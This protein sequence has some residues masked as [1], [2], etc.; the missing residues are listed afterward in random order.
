MGRPEIFLKNVPLF[1]D[2]SVTDIRRIA[3]LVEP[4]F[5]RKGEVLFRRG[6]EGTAFYIIVTG[7]IKIVRQSS[8]GEEVV[9]AILKNGDFL[10]EM[11]L[12][13]GLP[14]SADAVALEETNLYVLSRTEFFSFV[15]NNESA[16]K[17]ILSSLSVRLR[18][19]DDFLEDSSFLNLSSRLLKRIVD[20]AELYCQDEVKKG[21]VSFSMTQSE[22]ASMIGA[23]RESV[24]K[25]FRNLREK[26]LLSTAGKTITVHDIDKIK[27][28]VRKG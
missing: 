7:K 17:S 15:I 18:K 12:L 16:I 4:Q 21:R 27:K 9:L 10:G 28:L 24:N 8:L 19:A 3:E 25:E 1:C 5:I 26:G 6:E 20:L 2:L 23:T 11:S 22:I 14:R 13:D